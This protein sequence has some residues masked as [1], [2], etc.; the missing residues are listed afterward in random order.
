MLH[1]ENLHNLYMS[2]N[3]IEESGSSVGMETKLGAGKL[4]NRWLTSSREKRFFLSPQHPDSLLGSSSLPSNRQQGLF[5][6]G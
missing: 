3:I 6:Q 1:Y 4:R 2:P 5:P